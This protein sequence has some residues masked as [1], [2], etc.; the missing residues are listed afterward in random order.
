[1]SDGATAQALLARIRQ[2]DAADLERLKST[3]LPE[4]A[5]MAIAARIVA[6]EASWYVVDR[7]KR[8]RAE[9]AIEQRIEGHDASPAMV[10]DVL[11]LL[12]WELTDILVR[13]RERG[14][15]WF[16]AAMRTEGMVQALEARMQRLDEMA[17]QLAAEEA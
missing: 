10:K 17:E 6:D 9:G 14:T 3:L 12:E 1:M 16:H 2:A 13:I 15:E 7:L 11:A 8:L 4:R 5:G